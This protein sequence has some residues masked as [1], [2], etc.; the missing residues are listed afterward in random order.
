MNKVG[1]ETYSAENAP[2]ERKY[3]H[4]L[5]IFAVHKRCGRIEDGTKR[6]NQDTGDKIQTNRGNTH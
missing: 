5:R 2:D 3:M 6:N 1:P 4:L